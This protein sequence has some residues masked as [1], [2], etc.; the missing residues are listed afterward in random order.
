MIHSHQ[1]NRKTKR[2]IDVLPF[3]V[4]AYN[5]TPHKSTKFTPFQIFRRKNEI[6]KIDEIVEK[7]IQQNAKEM[8]RKFAKKM[9]KQKLPKLEGGEYCRIDTRALKQTRKLTQIDRDRMRKHRELNN[10]TTGSEVY[11]VLNVVDFEDDDGSV[12]SKYFLTSVDVNGVDVS[13]KSFYREQLLKVNSAEIIPVQGKDAVGGSEIK[14]DTS[15][16]GLADEVEW[17]DVKI[18]DEKELEEAEESWGIGGD[19]LDEK[20][21]SENETLTTGDYY[22]DVEDDDVPVVPLVLQDE[23]GRPK[24]KQL[25]YAHFDRQDCRR[26]AIQ[27]IMTLLTGLIEVSQKKFSGKIFT[28]LQFHWSGN[29]RQ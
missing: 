9:S 11:V 25:D 5:S 23:K 19:E 6:F 15:Y 22:S 18:P 12:V 29:C 3:F 27:V 24:K 1:Q 26:E 8:K 16:Y 4:F 7:N 2:Y 17:D 28:I 14:I 13:D 21:G 10:F 20:H